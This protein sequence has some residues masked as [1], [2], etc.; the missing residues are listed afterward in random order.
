MP[1]K[2]KQ[3]LLNH[4]EETFAKL[5]ESRSSSS[6]S[7][8]F[9][10]QIMCS[11]ITLRLTSSQS[12]SL[13]PFAAWYAKTQR[14]SVCLLR[15]LQSEMLTINELGAERSTELLH[16]LVEF[17]RIICMRKNERE[18]S[19]YLSMLILKRKKNVSIRLNH[20]CE[21]SWVI[22]KQIVFFSAICLLLAI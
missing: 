19:S 6:E 14:V 18:T 1:H 15:H 10:R 3:Q 22:S 17:I 4:A 20:L 7:L 12:P 16:P 8:T 5:F 9:H 2:S 21:A 11:F 13:S